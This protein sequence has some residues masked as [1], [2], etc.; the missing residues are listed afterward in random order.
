VEVPTEPTEADGE[1]EAVTVIAATHAVIETQQSGTMDVAG[2]VEIIIEV[3]GELAPDLDRLTMID[4]TDQVV[5]A[6]E[7][8]MTECG[9]VAHVVIG[10]EAESVLPA[11]RG[12]PN[13]RPRSPRR[14]SV[15]GA[16]SSC[17]SLPHA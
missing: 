12:R 5:G 9:T 15:I 11:P 2:Q 13:P 3:V 10:T 14:M 1:A 4:T 6:G 16:Q 17:N 8:M 7:M